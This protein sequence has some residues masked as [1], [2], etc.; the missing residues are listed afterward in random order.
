MCGIRIG[1]LTGR[2]V[3]ACGSTFDILE[4]QPV[5]TPIESVA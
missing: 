3:L 5:S 2:P 4:D 1:V